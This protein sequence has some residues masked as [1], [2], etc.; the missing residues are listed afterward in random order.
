MTIVL[1]RRNGKQKQ[2]KSLNTSHWACGCDSVIDAL[3][4]AR[5][6]RNGVHVTTR[7]GMPLK[8]SKRKGWGQL[9]SLSNP[10]DGRGS[11]VY[12][13]VQWNLG[14]AFVFRAGEGG[15]DKL[16]STLCISGADCLWWCDPPKKGPWQSHQ[17][18]GAAAG[19]R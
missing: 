1:N 7:L 16:L 4:S 2:R 5:R 10:S 6:S 18:P 8:T 15:V 9:Q 11:K 14:W 13:P 3:N 17:S 19:S 12:P